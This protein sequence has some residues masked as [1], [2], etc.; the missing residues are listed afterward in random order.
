MH[1]HLETLEKVNTFLVPFALI[2]LMGIIV[3]DLFYHIQDP[4]ILRW[5]N[6]IDYLIIT[7][8]V[9]E[10]IFFRLRS[11]DN[12]SFIKRYWLD[13]LVI[14]PLGTAFAAFGRLFEFAISIDGF[15]LGQKLVHE[16]IGLSKLA[17]E[18][19]EGILKFEKLFA[20]I[21]RFFVKV[22]PKSDSNSSGL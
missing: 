4:R 14:L 17:I 1:K 15:L 20:R 10:L 19:E 8:F 5:I 6:I 18:T 2:G 3:L 22:F 16:Y 21:T 12:I 13:I 7:V 9:I 11:E